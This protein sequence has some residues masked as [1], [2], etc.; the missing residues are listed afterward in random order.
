MKPKSQYLFNILFIFFVLSSEK[1]LAAACCGGGFAAPSIIAGD[2]KAQLTTSMASNELVVDN[3]DSSGLWH[4]WDDHQKNKTFKIEAAHIFNDRWQIGFSLP[5]TQRTYQDKVF[6]G[7]S[8]VATSIG[9]EYL[10]DW[11]YNPYRPKGIGYLQIIL[12]TGKSKADSEEGGLDSRGNGFWAIGA[13]T[14]LTKTWGEWD[15]FSSFEIHY[16]FGKK[17][18][19]SNLNGTLTPGIGTQFGIGVGYNISDFRIG[20]SLNWSYEDAI[21]NKLDS[22]VLEE[23]SIERFA[24]SNLSLSYLANEEWSG[25]IAYSD[26]TLF[27]DPIN[28]SLSRGISLQIQRRWGR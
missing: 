5:I 26:Q 9:Y 20:S 28:T 25:T 22:G 12:P 21:K 3:V 7:L 23:G 10:P 17:I 18:S 24:T 4:N 11:N 6:S 15:A 19:N 14:L 8:D 27:G 1:T 16:S 13:G 2:D